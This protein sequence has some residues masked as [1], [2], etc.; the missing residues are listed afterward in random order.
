METMFERC[1][2][3]FA[4]KSAAGACPVCGYEDGLCDLP[5][6]LLSPG[7]V[8]K[9][10]YMV[11]KLLRQGTEQMCYLGWDIKA[12]C[13]VEIT[14]YYPAQLV[15]R[16]ITNSAAVSCIPNRSAELERGKQAFF[17]RAKLFYNCVSRVQSVAMDFFVRNNT[18]YHVRWKEPLPDDEIP[19]DAR[20]T[21]AKNDA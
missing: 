10:K 9:G 16:D 14:E 19:M 3:C 7:T 6:Y 2:Y 18:C 4:P 1:I 5:A 11:G 15:T 17:E 8:L 12:Q 20:P 13:Q 21:V